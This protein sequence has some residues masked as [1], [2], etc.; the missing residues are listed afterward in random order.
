MTYCTNQEVV[1]EFDANEIAQVCSDGTDVLNAARLQKSREAAYNLI[2]SHIGT[3]YTLPLAVVVPIL[4][5]CEA[6]LVRHDLYDDNPT[7]VI[8]DRFNY[9]TNWLIDLTR[10]K[11]TLFDQNDLPV[12]K[13]TN[14]SGSDGF[15]VM[16]TTPKSFTDIVASNGDLTSISDTGLAGWRY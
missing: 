13:K 14:S 1:D 2:N 10:G 7:Q 15:F 8:V 5:K 4:K 3:K 11:I 6:N 9:W 12:P 16:Q